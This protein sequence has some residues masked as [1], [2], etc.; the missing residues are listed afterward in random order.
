[1][2]RSYPLL[3]AVVFLALAVA[4][5]QAQF[6]LNGYMIGLVE[7]PQFRA[8]FPLTADQLER[9]AKVTEKAREGM[10]GPP[11]LIG[12]LRGADRVKAKKA[13]EALKASRQKV[14]DAYEK[15]LAS[16]LTPAQL[17]R[18]R[19][20]TL[21]ML[22]PRAFEDQKA[23]DALKLSDDQR[24]KVD[25]LLKE[26]RQEARAISRLLSDPEKRKEAAARARR[27]DEMLLEKLVAILDQG[28]RQTWEKLLGDPLP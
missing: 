26:S 3:P 14:A 12:D 27:H 18:L 15:E 2:I 28:Q 24:A 11:E 1:M 21:R 13:E 17:K 8:E 5:A 16:I 22:G 6:V 7:R 4:P 9:L 20:I 25:L 23:R 19:Q 10:A